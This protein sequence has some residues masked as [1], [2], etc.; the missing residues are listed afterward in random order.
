MVQ[1]KRSWDSGEENNLNL[2]KFQPTCV[3]SLINSLSI[4]ISGVPQWMKMMPEVDRNTYSPVRFWK[5]IHKLMHYLQ[6]LLREMD[7]LSCSNDIQYDNS[8]AYVIIWQ[9]L[10]LILLLLLLLCG[11]LD[12]IRTGY[13]LFSKLVIISSHSLDGPSGVKRFW[14]VLMPLFYY[15]LLYGRNL[16]NR[17]Q[18]CVVSYCF[19]KNA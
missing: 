10:F 5:G 19:V 9:F 11:E 17:K 4:K 18:L 8:N 16:Q 2:L 7:T 12:W 3:N 14:R 6:G 13:H 1:S 15:N